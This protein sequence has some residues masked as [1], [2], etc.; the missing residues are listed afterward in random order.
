MHVITNVYLYEGKLRFFGEGPKQLL[1]GIE[2]TGSLRAAAMEMGMSYS[3]AL[4]MVSNIEKV[5]GKPVTEKKIGG[6][7]GGGSRLTKEAILLLEKYEQ[8]QAA[9]VENNQKLYEQFWGEKKI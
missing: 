4:K 8:Y 6:I 5:L 3:K 7:G 2:R 1:H 9:C